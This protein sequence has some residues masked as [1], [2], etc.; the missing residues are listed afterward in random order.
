MRC[1]IFDGF[2]VFTLWFLHSY[3]HKQCEW[4]GVIAI[5][6]VPLQ[7]YLKSARRASW[8]RWEI[9]VRQECV[10]LIDWKER[11][12]VSCV[13]LLT[14]ACLKSTQTRSYQ[15]KT[16]YP[17]R[18]PTKLV[19]LVTNQHTTLF[20]TILL[21]VVFLTHKD[22][23]SGTFIDVISRGGRPELRTRPINRESPNA[24]FHQA[25]NRRGFVV[26]PLT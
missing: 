18:C 4:A 3:C 17:P 7:T 9:R 12:T 2:F 22:S 13:R 20:L 15:R 23:V 11:S 8:A 26:P 21:S 14:M 25:S 24:F 16:R 6:A 10:V 1:Y 5:E 19:N